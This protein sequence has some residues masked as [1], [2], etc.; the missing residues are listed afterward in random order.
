MHRSSFHR[1]V[2][3]W[4]KLALKF[5]LKKEFFSLCVFLSQDRILVSRGGIPISREFQEQLKGTS[6]LTTE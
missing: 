3:P 1:F 2:V 4:V 6:T 5:I